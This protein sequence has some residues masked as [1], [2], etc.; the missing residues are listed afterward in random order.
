VALAA[1]RYVQRH[2]DPCAVMRCLGAT[3]TL[4]LR[5]YLGQFAV[6]GVLAAAVGCALGYLAHFAL[7]AWLAQ[8]LATPLPAP[9]L[10]PAV[11]GVAVGLLLLFGFAVP[12]LLQLK[13]VSTLRVLRRELGSPRTR[14]A[15][16][17]SAGLPGARRADVLGG[18]RGRTRRLRGRWLQHRTA[19]LCPDWRVAVRL[20]AALRGSGR[21]GAGG[22]RESAGAMVWRALSGER[23]RASSRLSPGAR[24]HGAAAVDRVRGDLLD[25]W[26]RAV[27]PEAPNRFVINIQPDQ[28]EPVR[29]ALA[30]QGLSPNWHRWCAGA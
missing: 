15:W 19:R 25:A 30:A 7:H 3:Q 9:G 4:L 13:K 16:R 6:L 5:L 12:P 28:V 29:A 22:Q 10:L 20:A 26:R 21:S 8:L 17:L 1:R 11:Q 18:W 23:A 14:S 2:L 27:P 24:L